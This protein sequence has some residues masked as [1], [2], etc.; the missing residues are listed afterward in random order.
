MKV[1][2]QEIRMSLACA[3]LGALLSIMFSCLQCFGP[4]TSAVHASSDRK[5]R[6]AEAREQ[7]EIL[8]GAINAYH[9]DMNRYPSQAEG[10]KALCASPDYPERL[11]WR[12]PYLWYRIPRGIYTRELR[13]EAV[14]LVVEG[15]ESV[16]Y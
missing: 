10:L 7:I 2:R 11:K 4:G 6:T 14:K 9:R 8:V 15:G 5:A 12:G 1:H 16:G 3:A 13:E